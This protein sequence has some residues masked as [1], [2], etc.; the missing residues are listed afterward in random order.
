MSTYSFSPSARSSALTTTYQAFSG[1]HSMGLLSSMVK[2]AYEAMRRATSTLCIVPSRSQCRVTARD[3]VTQTASN[4][5]ESFVVGSL[6]TVETYAATLSDPELGE[7]L[8]H[9]IAVY[10]DGLRP[11]EQSLALRLFASGYIRV[12]IAPREACWTLPVHASLVIVL[13]AQ[14]ASVRTADSEREI[15]DY[16]LSEL[17]QMQTLAVPPPEAGSAECLVLCQK[18]Q[19]ELYGRFLLEGVPLESDLAFDPVL[20]STLFADVVAGRIGDRQGVADWLSWTYLARR[21][22][23][24]PA[25]YGA[26][27]PATQKDD[28][29]SRLVDRLVGVLEARCC[30]LASG[31]TGFA[32]SLL[33]K[34]FGERGVGVED[35]RR[36]QETS[37]E[38]LVQL[39]SSSASKKKSTEKANGELATPT[40]GEEP[41]PEETTPTPPPVVTPLA[42]FHQRLPRAVRDAIGPEG[43]EEGKDEYSRR[44]LLA[45][46]SAGRVPRGAGGLEEE[47]AE[48]V[49][50]LSDAKV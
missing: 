26:L 16:P 2:P 12:L 28:Q 19:A 23:A 47:Q 18:D 42:N 21:V 14:F 29:V 39:S 20:L 50:R 25:Y 44:I 40:V 6:E 43:G 31:K 45:A 35:V 41:T 17:L 27:G 1:A 5:E 11:E 15:H 32:P 3:L 4:L 33:G 30:V 34:L 8:T 13:S 49:R 38:R 7:A 48:L 37:L 46:F 10:H 9:G 24:N 36:I 22:E